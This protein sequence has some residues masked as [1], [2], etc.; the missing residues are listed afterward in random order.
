MTFGVATFV[1][2]TVIAYLVGLIWKTSDLDDKWI[3]CVVGTV[4]L[5]LGIAGYLLNVPDFPASDI[6]TAAAVGTASG[7]AAV[8]IN[9]IKKQLIDINN[10][11]EKDINSPSGPDSHE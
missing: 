2:I 6:L 3:P 1:A 9:Q 7:F 10:E 5:A 11:A 4:G 8:G